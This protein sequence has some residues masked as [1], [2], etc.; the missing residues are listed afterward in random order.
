MAAFDKIQIIHWT[1]SFVRALFTLSPDNV[2]DMPL[3]HIATRGL[4]QWKRWILRCSS[5]DPICTP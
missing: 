3:G 1:S 2:G 4:G 5:G